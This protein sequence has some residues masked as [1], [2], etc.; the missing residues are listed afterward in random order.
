MQAQLLYILIGAMTASLGA[1]TDA[2]AAD[3]SE[4]AE[5]A[6]PILRTADNMGVRIDRITYEGDDVALGLVTPR[7]LNDLQVDVPLHDAREP[8]SMQLAAWLRDQLA[9][10]PDLH[11][12]L[13]QWRFEG[14]L[15][16]LEGTGRLPA[17]GVA[18]SGPLPMVVDVHRSDDAQASIAVKAP[19][20]LFDVDWTWIG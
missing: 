16:D 6:S 17:E 13:S 9:D 7:G 8:A 15:F 18:V 20:H 14:R 4:A 2:D 1:S 11:W 5:A 10:R 19:T 12:I 3:V